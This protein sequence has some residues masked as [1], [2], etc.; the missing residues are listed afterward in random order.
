MIKNN[1]KTL[2]S[3]YDPASKEKNEVTDHSHTTV[4]T[5]NLIYPHYSVMVVLNNVL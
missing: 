4:F 2:G 3:V 1:P 5:Q